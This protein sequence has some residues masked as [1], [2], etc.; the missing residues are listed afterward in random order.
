MPERSDLVMK[1]AETMW[2]SSPIDKE[3]KSGSIEV[4]KISKGYEDIDRND[5]A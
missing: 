1:N 3:V 5:S 2:F 4:L